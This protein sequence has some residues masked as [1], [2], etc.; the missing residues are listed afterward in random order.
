MTRRKI[1]AFFRKD[2][3]I[4]NSPDARGGYGKPFLKW[5]GGKTQLAE[6]ILRTFPR[7]LF[8]GRGMTYVEPFVGGGAI[9]FRLLRERANVARAVVNDVN[10]ALVAT[11]RR[12]KNAPDALVAALAE[13]EREY[14]ALP[15]TGEARREFFLARRSEFNAAT[16][17]VPAFELECAERV[18][19]LLIFLNR[20]C[21]NGLFRV[22]ARGEFNV[23][24]GKYKNP[25]ICDEATIRADSALLR[26]TEILCGDFAKTLDYAR[27]G[28]ALFYLDPPYKP[29]SATS[30][31][32]AYAQGGFDDAEQTRL[33]DFCREL[34]ARGAK[35]VLSNSDARDAAGTSFFDEL[36]AGFNVRRVYASRMVNADSSKRGKLAEVLISNF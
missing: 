35:F 11:Y 28:N 12:V 2:H 27:G 7:E 14:L 29:L 22:N 20:T 9:L 5:V 4:G 24:F 23:P 34:D 15:E 1:P 6:E 26:N 30:S 36:Y 10:P 25:K 31:F 18:P 8:D 33:R 17:G 32:N 16:A 3:R 21:F 13:L 19:A